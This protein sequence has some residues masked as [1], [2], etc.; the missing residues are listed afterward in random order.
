M[1]TVHWG[2][3]KRTSYIL[4]FW[5]PN[6]F[7]FHRWSAKISTIEWKSWRFKNDKDLI[8]RQ[9][10][11]NILAPFMA[12]SL[13][14]QRLRTKCDLNFEGQVCI[15]SLRRWLFEFQLCLHFFCIL[16]FCICN[17]ISRTPRK[18]H[19]IIYW[20]VEEKEREVV[21]AAAERWKSLGRPLLK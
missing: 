5:E 6:I 19:L 14:V 1:Q 12:A 8:K 18:V 3:F 21:A 7:R 20:W 9:N 16:M 15:F 17:K 11:S 4:Y 2:R 10:L 13:Y